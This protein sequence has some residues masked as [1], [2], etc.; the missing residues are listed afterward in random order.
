MASFVSLSTTLCAALPGSSLAFP[1]VRG[2]PTPFSLR[3]SWTGAF[4]Q[5]VGS[6]P[7]SLTLDCFFLPGLGPSPFGS[8]L[9]E[10]NGH[11]PGVERSLLTWSSSLW[12]CTG[13]FGCL[14][15][16]VPLP[17]ADGLPP[18]HC[19]LTPGRPLPIR[20]ASC[21]ASCLREEQQAGGF[22]EGAHGLP[23]RASDP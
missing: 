3:L 10:M 6:A 9:S 20:A 13:P 5:D 1:Y 23:L 7:F 16:R 11:F 22:W 14:A 21:G 4:P 2:G 19:R 17:S 8:L 18:G 15:F 12:F